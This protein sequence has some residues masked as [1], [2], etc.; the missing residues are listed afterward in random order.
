MTF[1]TRRQARLRSTRSPAEFASNSAHRLSQSRRL[2]LDRSAPCRSCSL[3][4]SA[5]HITELLCE[6]T[7]AARKLAHE[8]IITLRGPHVA[9]TR[10]KLPQQTGRSTEPPP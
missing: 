4:S 6:R 9:R 1:P 5:N 10:R 2:H 7:L 8:L 3:P